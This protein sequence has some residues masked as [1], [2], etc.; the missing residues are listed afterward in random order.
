MGKLVT[1]YLVYFKDSSG[2]RDG[3][4]IIEA[5]NRKEALE[6]YRQYFN[7]SGKCTVIPRIEVSSCNRVP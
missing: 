4:E 1:K 5:K 3:V 7:V 2:A 6:I